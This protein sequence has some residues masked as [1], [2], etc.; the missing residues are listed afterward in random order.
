VQGRRLL[1]IYVPESSQVHRVRVRTEN[2]N[3]PQGFGALNPGN[4]TS[5]P[6]K[7]VLAGFFRQIGQAD[8]LGSGMRNMIKYGKVYGGEDPELIEGDVFRIIIRVP[9]AEE[10]MG[11]ECRVSINIEAYNGLVTPQVTPQVATLLKAVGKSPKTREE[12]IENADRKHFRK[13]YREPLQKAGWIE[14]TIPDKPPS[15]VPIDGKR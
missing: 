1:R 10:Q 12:L 2:S 9:E 7:P 14:K 15:E 3:K 13:A 8:E 6:K 4:F 11:N 5:F